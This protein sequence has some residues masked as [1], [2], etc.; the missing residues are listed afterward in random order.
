MLE[1]DVT[2]KS[3]LC[4][5]CVFSASTC[6]I[7]AIFFKCVWAMFSFPAAG[8]TIEVAPSNDCFALIK[9]AVCQ[10]FLRISP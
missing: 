6:F 5:V 9:T 7:F 3:G 8:P 1:G 4:A 2:E 10:R